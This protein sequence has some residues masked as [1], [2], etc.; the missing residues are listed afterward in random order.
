MT[1]SGG[2][3]TASPT[4]ADPQGFSVDASTGAITGTPR[5]V[6]D[7]YRM[8]LRAVDAANIRTD[9]ANWTFNVEPSPEFSLN[10]SAGWS[11][12]TDGQLDNKYHI[13]ETHLL[14]K[15]RLTTA[16][17]LQYPA[18]G[19]FGKVV[20]LL[21][22]KAAGDNPSCT[23]AKV[24]SALTDV[25]TG[26]GAIDI[27]CEGNYSAKLVV[28]DGAGKEVTLRSWNFT[29]RRRDTTVPAYGPNGHGC[30]NGLPADGKE[31][32]GTFTCDCGGT[33]FT[34]K[35][36]ETTSDQDGTSATVVGAVLGVL[37]LSAVVVFL[38]LRWQR[39][40]RSMMATDFLEQLEAMKERGE[41]DEAQALKGGVPRELKRGWLALIDTLGKGAFGEVWK[42]L[43]QDG[44]NPNIPAYMVACKVVKEV[45]GSL[46]S[47]GAVAAEEELLKEA[48]LMAQVETHLHLVSLVG[49]IT[50]GS[51]KVLVLSFCEH[52]ELQGALKK[53]AAD[54]DAFSAA[55][56]CDFCKEIADGMAHLAQHNFVHRDLA[57][58]N[59]LLGSGMVCKVADFGLSRR[60][61]T[62]DNTGDY[63]RSSS[64][65]I[66]VRWTAPEG[67]ASQKFSSAS[68]VWSYGITCVEIFQ[69]GMAPYPGVKSNPEVIKLVCSECHVHPRPK[70]CAAEIYAALVKCWSFDPDRRPDFSSLASF[71]LDVA[72][73]TAANATATA[74]QGVPAAAGGGGGG[75]GLGSRV[76]GAS[77]G[78]VY[79]LGHQDFGTAAQYNLGHQD[80]GPAAGAQYNLGHQDFG[81]A[82]GAQHN[83]GHQDFGP[84]AGAQYNLGYQNAGEH[85]NFG[86]QGTVRS[87]FPGAGADAPQQHEHRVH[88]GHGDGASGLMPDFWTAPAP[89]PLRLV[90]PPLANNTVQSG[91]A[92]RGD[93]SDGAALLGLAAGGDLAST[94]M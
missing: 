61:Q 71:F 76:V 83:L 84:A 63:Y 13:D 79:N 36:C 53:R 72:A 28:R 11:T 33:K 91:R 23:A 25:E 34:G 47:A 50:R 64:G 9:V 60:V 89:E 19:D 82:A 21:S 80:F 39:Y 78:E 8:R 7:G 81:P 38:L 16:G 40:T 20:Y 92:D 93:R 17:L 77:T 4:D 55:E 30:T 15:P 6:R 62:E 41:V 18:G 22:A 26:E 58:R 45:A 37:V 43:L 49:V 74:P 70:G 14:P 86:H 3:T 44:G 85:Y 46:D 27:K 12:E 67:V 5:K 10:S 65:I 29:A 31:M 73:S 1:C 56:K 75:S 87:R 88:H 54:G 69:D 42:G 32:D 59:V 24:I 66:P 68:D 52:G 35:N 57:A 51:P 94:T 2:A 48:L 90:Q